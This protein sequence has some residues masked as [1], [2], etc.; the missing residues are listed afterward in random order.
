MPAAIEIEDVTCRLGRNLALDGVSL[1]V[2]EG[3]VVGLVGANGAGKTTLVDVVCGLRRPRRGTVRV[4]GTAVDRDPAAARR[5]IGL[6]P[7]ET[8]LYEEVSAR[9]NLRLM[10]DLHGVRD[11]GARLAE[12]LELVGLTARSRDRVSTFSGGM[13]RRLAI[14]RA[15]VHDPAVL[16]LDEPTLGVDLEARHQIWEHVRGLRARGRAVLLTTN[17]L[18]EAEA[19]CDRVGLLSRGRL[20]GEDTPQGLVARAGRCLE[21]DCEPPHRDELR[22]T[23]SG[24][25]QVLR[26]VPSA[27][28][29]TLYLDQDAAPELV[30]R[31]AM[32]LAP[33]LGFRVRSPDLAEVFRAVVAEGGAG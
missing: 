18:D 24:Q 33:L 20:V 17:Y 28:G 27:A 26:V 7:Q 6:V 23:L 19:L 13:R 25:R 16:V 30:A 3:E 15:L 32:E 2:E 29:L 21:L 14:A 22:R 1:R 9:Q 31:R 10:A 12:V 8:A 4:L 11:A 5:A